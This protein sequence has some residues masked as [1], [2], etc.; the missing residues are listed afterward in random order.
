MASVG[1]RATKKA[2]PVRTKKDAR[3]MPMG[4]IAFSLVVAAAG[5]LAYWKRREGT[6]S[7]SIIDVSATVSQKG[8]AVPR[9]PRRS[10]ADD[11]AG[12]VWAGKG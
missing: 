4:K 7:E 9:A 6:R 8:S 11:V 3:V 5:G 1:S 2:K 10:I 12:G